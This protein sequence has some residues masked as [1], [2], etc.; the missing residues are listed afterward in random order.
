MTDS[1]PESL[2]ILFRIISRRSWDNLQSWPAALPGSYVERVMEG[3]DIFV[4][5]V[6]AGGAQGIA[7]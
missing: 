5:H 7:G 6:P 4:L 3:T 2:M 1:P